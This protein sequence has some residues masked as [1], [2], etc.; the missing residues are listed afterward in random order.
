MKLSH[1]LSC[2]FYRIIFF[3]REID[4]EREERTDFREMGLGDNWRQN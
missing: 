1:T 3:C 4:T 2:T